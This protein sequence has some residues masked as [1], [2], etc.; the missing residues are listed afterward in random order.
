M[1]PQ[2]GNP[3]TRLRAAVSVLALVVAVLLGGCSQATPNTTAVVN[4]VVI[5][6]S[7]VD[8]MAEALVSTGAKS[9]YADARATSAYTLIL[10]EVARQVAAQQ[11]VTLAPADIAALSTN[12]PTY[13]TFLSTPLGEQYA[14]DQ[15]QVNQVGAQVSDWQA[16]FAKANVTLNPRYGS[17]ADLLTQLTSTGSMVPPTGSMSV[18]S[19][20]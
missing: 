6:E 13:A 10:G 4:G 1:T 8:Q 16:D 17:W 19:G 2:E 20:S 5:H 12:N 18:T 15:V 3:V 9:T 7:S 11:G 14:A